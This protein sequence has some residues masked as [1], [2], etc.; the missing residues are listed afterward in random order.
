MEHCI[1]SPEEEW[2]ETVLLHGDSDVSKEYLND[3]YHTLYDKDNALF[4]ALISNL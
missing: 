4:E 1:M 2:L 3:I